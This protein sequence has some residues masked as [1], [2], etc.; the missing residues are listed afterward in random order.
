MY[1]FHLLCVAPR[2]ENAGGGDQ[3]GPDGRRHR[4]HGRVDGPGHPRQAGPH[5]GGQQVGMDLALCYATQRY[6]ILHY[7]TQRYSM[8]HYTTIHNVTV[9]YTTIHSV[10]V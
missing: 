4:R 8:L 3:A 5:R 1:A 10:T 6:S 2:P 9:C 7:N